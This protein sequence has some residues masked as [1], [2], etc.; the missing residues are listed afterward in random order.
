MLKVFV[1]TRVVRVLV[2]LACRSGRGFQMV[3]VLMWN[4]VK[5][6]TE[7]AA[8]NQLQLVAA[9]ANAMAL[10]VAAIMSMALSAPL[11]LVLVAMP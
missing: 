4:R 7:I 2:S 3:L 1:A 8:R 5:I 9:T 6:P 10:V 11:L